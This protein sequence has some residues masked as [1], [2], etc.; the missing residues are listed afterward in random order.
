M[1]E[2]VILCVEEGVKNWNE[3]RDCFCR[4]GNERAENERTEKSRGRTI[5]TCRVSLHL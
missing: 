2:K 1:M 3:K 5:V 4:N